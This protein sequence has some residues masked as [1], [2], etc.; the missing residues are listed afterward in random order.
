MAISQE[1]LEKFQTLLA[2]LSARFP[3]AIANAEELADSVVEL[4]QVDRP[5][6]WR[7]IWTKVLYANMRVNRA[8]QFIEMLQPYL[9]T[10]PS[11][12]EHWEQ[13]FC[14]KYRK[15]DRHWTSSQNYEYVGM[16]VSEARR[17]TGVAGRRLNAIYGAGCAFIRWNSQE[18]YRLERLSLEEQMSEIQSQFG[19]GW[20]TITVAHLLTDLGLA[21]KPDLHL[22]NTVCRLGIYDWRRVRPNQVPS[23]RHILGIISAVNELN[24]VL[25]KEENL[26]A[27]RR[28]LR[29]LDKILMEI[30]RSGVLDG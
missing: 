15:L 18:L 22:V 16:S 5:T 30:S 29:W 8:K 13:A 10:T 28:K 26:A 25:H 1:S 9:L 14:V 12:L 4:T 23:A 3:E 24:R 2:T 21:I 6:M 7:L 17:R 20:G 19:L 27:Q 11:I